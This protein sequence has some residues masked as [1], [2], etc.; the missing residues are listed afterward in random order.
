M[1]N[2]N[3]FLIG[4]F[5]LI[6]SVSSFANTISGY[7]YDKDTNK[8]LAFANVYLANTLWGNAT[9]EK[10]HYRINNIPAGFYDI[11]VQLVGY[12]TYIQNIYVKEDVP[13]KISIKLIPYTYKAG[14]IKVEA[15]STDQWQREL[16][17][18]KRLFY[19]RTEAARHCEIMNSEVL[20]FKN[21]GSV[22]TA[23]ARRPLIIMNYA[24]GY[25][26]NC[27]LVGFLWDKERLLLSWKVQAQFSEI[28]PDSPE[29]YRQWQKARQEIYD[30]SLEGFLGWIVQPNRPQN[31]YRTSTVRYLPRKMKKKKSSPFNEI[32]YLSMKPVGH[33]SDVPPFKI[34]E[35][36]ILKPGSEPGSYKLKF[37]DYLQVIELESEQTSYLR[38]VDSAV[39]IDSFGVCSQAAPFEISGEWAN[40]GIA[41][42][43][44]LYFNR[45]KN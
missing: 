8:P 3:R 18:F 20:D 40:A 9:D 12:K 4:A 45:K 36:S 24:L 19:G 35:N 41:N 25:K 10:G 21:N 32:P 37:A 2:A 38:L 28:A 5:I 42:F 34:D 43:L 7:V 23:T 27:I 17:K 6:C 1:Q 26:L 30:R 22:F 31:K 16:R 39:V 13:K 29:Q 15:L 33:Y 14:S 11:V 44:P